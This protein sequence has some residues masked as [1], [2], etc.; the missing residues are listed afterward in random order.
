VAVDLD[1]ALDTAVGI[2]EMLVAAIAPLAG[3]YRRIGKAGQAF[4]SIQ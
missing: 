3:G 4:R 1:K 2:L